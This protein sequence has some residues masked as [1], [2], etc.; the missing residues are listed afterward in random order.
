VIVC[1]YQHNPPKEIIM[2][3]PNAMPKVLNDA[4]LPLNLDDYR[5]NVL[6]L[7]I[8]ARTGLDTNT[9]LYIARAVPAWADGKFLVFPHYKHKH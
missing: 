8:G 3:T 4:V 2:A 6:P 9:V 5:G 1:T 7:S